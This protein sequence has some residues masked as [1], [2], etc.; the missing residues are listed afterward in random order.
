MLQID[1]IFQFGSRDD[2]GSV[3]T[4]HV[5]SLSQEVSVFATETAVKI[6]SIKCSWELKFPFHPWTPKSLGKREYSP[7]VP[8]ELPDPTRAEDFAFSMMYSNRMYPYQ[9]HKWPGHK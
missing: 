4:W 7:R 9:Q 6:L 2:D 3:Y 1:S 8:A 5:I